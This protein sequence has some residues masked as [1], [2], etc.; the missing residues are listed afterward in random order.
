MKEHLSLIE[1]GGGP[2][3]HLAGLCSEYIINEAVTVYGWKGDVERARFK[4][5]LKRRATYV[6]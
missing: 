5:S 4:G 6:I 2:V 3:D 1:D